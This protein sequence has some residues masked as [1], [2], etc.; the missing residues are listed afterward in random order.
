MKSFE[1]PS[2]NGRVLLIAYLT[3]FF[4]FQMLPVFIYIGQVDGL[5]EVFWRKCAPTL[6]Y[7]GTF[8]T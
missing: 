2:L 5:A 7:V 1:V 4:F 6:C 3:F 8:I